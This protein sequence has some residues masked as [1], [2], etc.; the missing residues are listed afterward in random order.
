MECQFCQATL[1][2]KY[3]LKRHQK[4]NKQCLKIQQEM[5]I[6][7][8]VEKKKKLHLCNACKKSY[9]SKQ[10][11]QNHVCKSSKLKND[12]NFRDMI[13]EFVKEEMDKKLK[14][15]SS[16]IINNNTN[17]NSNNKTINKTIN[18]YI[19]HAPINLDPQYVK[20]IVDNEFNKSHYNKGSNGFV[21]FLVENV[22]VK[23]NKI[24]YNVADLQR[25]KFVYKDKNDNVKNEINAELLLKSYTPPVKDKTIIFFDEE[26]KDDSEKTYNYKRLY[27][28]K[29]KE[30]V[31]TR[32]KLITD[33]TRSKNNEK[34]SNDIVERAKKD[35]VERELKRQEKE[36]NKY[37][38][39]YQFVI[40]DD[41]DEKKEKK[42]NEKKKK[43]LKEQEE[44]ANNLF[45]EF[46]LDNGFKITNDFEEKKVL[47]FIKRDEEEIKELDS[48][49]EELS[50]TVNDN[51]TKLQSKI[52]SFDNKND[53]SL[54][55]GKKLY[56]KV[57]SI[58][59]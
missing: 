34:A 28:S 39:Q 58:S 33:Y 22:C 15:N 49:I 7:G 26:N 50:K 23:D 11:L 13:A 21:E 1:A 30:D 17:T 53:I 52:K 2:N 29:R 55:L 10:Y 51:K 35:R 54:K 47:E 36:W 38:S 32:K 9:S 14:E 57:N 6:E 8:V 44:K 37:N 5:N 31:E 40:F 46:V 45:P 20:A 48:E 18:N 24:L 27:R 59:E 43:E 12:P 3:N 19:I 42:D 4:T 41:N 25:H 16:I 56:N